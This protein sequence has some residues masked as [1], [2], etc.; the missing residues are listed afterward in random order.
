MRTNGI[1]AAVG[2]W[3]ALF[4]L[5][6]LAAAQAQVTVYLKSGGEPKRG[7]AIRYKG[8]TQEYILSVGSV[9]IPLPL[10]SVE[11]VDLPKPASFA[12]AE[13]MVS[14]G[15]LQDAMPKLER[16]AS[17]YS[18]LEWGLRA[19]DLLAD[20]YGRSG[21]LA[22]SLSVYGELFRKAPPGMV[23]TQTRLKY[24]N[25]MLGAQKVDAL[26]TDLE[27]A[28]ARGS[29][30]DAA[31]AL[32]MRGNVKRSQNKTMDALLDYL[33]AALL[34]EDVTSIQP[35]ALF[36]AAEMMDAMRDPR[37][38]DLRKRLAQKFPDTEYGRKAAASM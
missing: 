27:T 36:K 21:N 14:A 33:R 23:P 7:S 30:E 31:C 28:I 18:G 19:E 24:W 10:D 8:S 16:L 4:F 34:Y 35:E 13:K 22:K 11:R 25:A 17:E 38:A 5:A 29:R 1:Q 6:S 2:R 37:G 20:C 12:E 3:A 32:L 9:E 26:T 15:R